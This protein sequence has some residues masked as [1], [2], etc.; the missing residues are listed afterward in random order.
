VPVSSD[1]ATEISATLRFS[2]RPNPD[3]AR[4]DSGC[5]GA[6]GRATSIT[7]DSDGSR[8][9]P[10]N[11]AVINAAAGNYLGDDMISRNL[12][13]RLGMLEE[14]VPPPEDQ[15]VI[16]LAFV[17]TDGTWAPGGFTLDPRP[18]VWKSAGRQ[19]RISRP[20]LMR[21]PTPNDQ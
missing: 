17:N 14:R 19:Q 11:A 8:R 16:R 9:G 12:S 10:Y 18:H 2:N 5:A 7:V 21:R 13:R 4:T 6:P 3:G 20:A 15:V 1:S